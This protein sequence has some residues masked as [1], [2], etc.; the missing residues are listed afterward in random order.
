MQANDSKSGVPRLTFRIKE[1]AEA[2]GMS[3]DSFERYVE[4]HIKLLRLGRLK[5]V[6]ASELQ[7]FVEENAYGVGGAW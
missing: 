5:L 3:E 2:L 1:A 6:P 7:R 4:S